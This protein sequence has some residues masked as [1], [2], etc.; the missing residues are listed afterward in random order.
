VG[1]FHCA[2]SFDAHG[3]ERDGGTAIEWCTRCL[4]SRE[5]AR[6]YRVTVAS[7]AARHKPQYW[8]KAPNGGV[9][10]DATSTIGPALDRLV[11][12]SSQR[13]RT[14]ARVVHYSITTRLVRDQSGP[15]AARVAGRNQP[16]P[17]LPDEPA[18]NRST[19]TAVGAWCC[20]TPGGAGAADRDW[21]ENLVTHGRSSV[22]VVVPRG[23]RTS[24][25]L[26]CMN[27]G[28]WAVFAGPLS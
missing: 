9:V 21:G 24:R 18:T 5:I 10:H 13:A 27:R 26:K 19:P 2:A 28:W 12:P 8:A 25:E 17:Y 6:R 22:A 11:R 1:G 20:R 4:A 3:A 14:R 7:R 15:D 23:T 16:P